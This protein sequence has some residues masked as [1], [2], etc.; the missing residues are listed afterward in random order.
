MLG[1]KLG[2]HF[3]ESH[4]GSYNAREREREAFQ[5]INR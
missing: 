5:I 1:T 4:S 2:Q 3:C